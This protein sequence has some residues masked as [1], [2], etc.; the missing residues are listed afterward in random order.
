MT[1]LNKEVLLPCPFCG[2][3]AKIVEGEESA[4]VQCLNMK[5]HRALWFDGDNNAA[6]EVAEQWN[7][8]A[9]L[10]MGEPVACR[11]AH[12]DEPFYWNLQKAPLSDEAVKND[13]LV[14]QLLY[15]TDAFPARPQEE[16]LREALRDLVGVVSAMRVPQ[17]AAFQIMVTIGPVLERARA[18][19]AEQ[20][21]GK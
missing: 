14:Q 7:T 3:P 10:P 2:G 8:R 16:Q 21:Q 9:A 13:R 11:W 5:M 17:E 12:A 1:D 20:E 4:Y 19:L 6:N 18:L 15:T